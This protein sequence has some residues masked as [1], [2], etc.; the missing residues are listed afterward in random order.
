MNGAACLIEGCD[1]MLDKLRA[2]LGAVLEASRDLQSSTERY[3][4]STFNFAATAW[5]LYVD[6][7]KKLGSR[8]QVN[9][10]S[11]L[12]N[13]GRII[14]EVWRDI[15]NASKH[16]K[17]DY[18][19][20]VASVS[21]PLVGDWQAFFLSRKHIYVQIGDRTCRITD[22]AEVT[23]KT[24]EWILNGSDAGFPQ[25]LQEN[26]ESILWNRDSSDA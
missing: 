24:F 6:W 7:L 10:K 11:A 8:V 20:Q 23:V 2:E 17:L 16:V 22:A 12:P 1:D 14:L 18:S 13:E 26:L 4:Y 3:R 25:D 9:R 5:H 19:G 15:A 21:P